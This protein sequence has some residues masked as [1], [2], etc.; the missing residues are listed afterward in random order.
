LAAGLAAFTL[1]IGFR[2]PD[3]FPINTSVS[4]D[5]LDPSAAADVIVGIIPGSYMF[6]NTL[7][8]GSNGFSRQVFVAGGEHSYTGVAFLRGSD[9]TVLEIGS[10]TVE[11]GNHSF[12]ARLR[13]RR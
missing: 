7:A 13:A 9:R 3:R 10:V 6:V 12:K 11:N 5:G 8:G 2:E 1:H 4:V